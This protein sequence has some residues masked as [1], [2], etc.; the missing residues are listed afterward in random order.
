MLPPLWWSSHRAFFDI[1]HA[2]SPFVKII[3][4][5][6]FLVNR[7]VLLNNNML[8]Y[9]SVPVK[10]LETIQDELLSVV[11]NRQRFST[12]LFYLP[13]EWYLEKPCTRN[14]LDALGLLDFVVSIAAVVVD[15][16]RSQLPIH[17]DSGPSEWSLN[18]PVRNCLG[19]FTTWY[20][21]HKDPIFTSREGKD[22]GY[23]NFDPAD[24]EEIG[25]V[26]MTHPHIVNVKVPHTVVNPTNKVRILCAIRLAPTF[27]IEMFDDIL[28]TS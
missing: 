20:R 13:K 11:P 23:D 3:L 7:F 28:Q 8:L 4:D 9:K 6:N 18:I 5:T 27:S 26:E 2:T 17:V 24:C 15:P 12:D 16:G 10:N 22:L 1:C 25:R 14:M 21:A 19:T